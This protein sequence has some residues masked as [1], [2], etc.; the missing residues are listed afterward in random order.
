MEK[1]MEPDKEFKD[2][3][4]VFV[5]TLFDEEGGKIPPPPK[6]RIFPV[7]SKMSEETYSSVYVIR[8]PKS[9]IGRAPYCDIIIDDM[10]VSRN[11]AYIL[12]ENFQNPDELPQCIL[13]DDNS[14]NGTLVND[15]RIREPRVLKDGDRILLGGYCLWYYVRS[16][17]ELRYDDN[18]QGILKKH[19]YKPIDAGV[20]PRL[21]VE[22]EIVFPEETFTPTRL[23]GILEYLSLTGIRVLTY[24]IHQ[25][26]YKQILQTNRY[27]RV[28]ILP[29]EKG[30]EFILHCRISWLNFEPQKQPP[31]CIMGLTLEKPSQEEKEIILALTKG[32]EPPTLGG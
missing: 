23:R 10:K 5:E 3:N 18:L 2:K 11:H 8:K 4:V 1:N 20:S 9:T 19:G 13:Y 32:Q 27:A 22:I 25:D 31:G 14:R 17:L 16:E 28:R 12:H 6:G 21:K 24:D 26:L 29:K 7:L 30:K 15:E